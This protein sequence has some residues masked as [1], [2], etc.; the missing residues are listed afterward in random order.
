MDSLNT[1][2]RCGFSPRAS[3]IRCTVAGLT[4]T[5]RAIVR[6]LQWVCPG[7]VECSVSS[8]ISAIFPGGIDGLRPRPL[9]TFPHLA[10]PSA[11]KR[12]RQARTDTAVV[13]N[14]AAILVLATPSAAA[15]NAF[16]RTTSRCGDVCDLA[17]FAKVAR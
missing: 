4:P 15:S 6:Q 10:S 8:T 12:C 2:T 1:S 5:R 17:T 9:P 13:P 3:Q 16:A 14:S 7:G 11:W